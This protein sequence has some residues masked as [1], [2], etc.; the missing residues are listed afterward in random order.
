MIL[1]VDLSICTHKIYGATML[2]N[3][4]IAVIPLT[5]ELNKIPVVVVR[6]NR[7]PFDHHVRN[8]GHIKKH[9]AAGIINIAV[10]GSSRKSSVCSLCIR[11]SSSYMNIRDVAVNP[12]KDI[13][14][15]LN[16]ILS[17]ES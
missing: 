11:K 15:S 1:V 6:C 16:I 7:R 3:S 9:L 4:G 13:S 10:S 14:C 5:I 2:E 12:V 8:A 17:P